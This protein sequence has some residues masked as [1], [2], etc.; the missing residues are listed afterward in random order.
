MMRDLLRLL[1]LLGPGWRWQALGVLL[2][3]LVVLSNVALLALSGWFIA[4]MGLAGL[5]LIRIEYFLP[6]AAIRALA[7]VR[8]LGRYLERLV[9]HEATFRLLANL[10]VW[11][12][13]HLE[14][15]APAGLQAHR[16]GDLMSRIRADIDSLDNVYLRVLAPS[17]TAVVS[18]A[19]IV[20][21]LGHFSWGA[22]LADL[23]G[24]LLVGLALPLIAF[25]LSRKTG[26]EAVAA[27]GA[28]RADL[29]D[30]LRGFEE[31]LVFGA[32]E[33]Q[34]GRHKAAY[35]RLATLQKRETG[36]E[37]SAAS[38]ALFVVQSTMLAAFALVVPLAALH[39]MP[40]A[41]IAMIVLL[42]L[43]SFDAVSGQP[44]AY[45][46]LGETLAAARR[47]F[48]I[49]DLPPPVA[50]PAREAP[51]PGRFDLRFS[52]VSLRYA[53]DAAWALRDISFTIPQGSAL[54]VIGPTGSGKTSMLHALLRFWEVQEGTITLGGVPISALS[55]EQMRGLCTVIAQ[56][57]HLF[58]TSITENLR[59]AKPDATEAEMR[60]ALADAGI[61]EEVDAMP[62][63]LATMV[64]EFGT[65]LSGGQARRIAIARAFLKDAPILLLDEPTEGLDAQSERIVLAALARLMQGRTTLLITHRRQAL[66][67]I[68][69]ILELNGGALRS[70]PSAEAT[71]LSGSTPTLP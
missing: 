40:S 38:A 12:Y 42:V 19:L 57:T 16:S 49:A 8:A 56:Q 27:R 39:A 17:V 70:H 15:L 30:T 53:P 48:E 5:G 47:L 2:G 9:T 43:A 50:E 28:L 66:R 36:V 60:A 46:A 41:D 71:G 22:A 25:R 14:P 52:H 45:R 24:L 7:I 1:R 13:R 68:D 64:G 65:A 32:M 18:V 54:G 11:F 31:L 35:A 44:A 10:R 62:Q 26:A 63:G 37:A 67:G 58:N 4:A 51:L 20:L 61:A 29:A 55:G 33:R 59:I 34:I 6:A 3:V 21:F 23:T 69:R